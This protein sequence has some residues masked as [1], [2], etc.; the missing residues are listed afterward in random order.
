M[1]SIWDGVAVDRKV[2]MKASNA[3]EVLLVGGTKSAACMAR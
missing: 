3:A 2:G 1:Y